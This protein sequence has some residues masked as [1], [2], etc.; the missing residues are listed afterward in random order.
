MMHFTTNFAFSNQFC[1]QPADVCATLR[2]KVSTSR[3]RSQYRQLWFYS[4]RIACQE[5]MCKFWTRTWLQLLDEGIRPLWDIK[6]HQSW[7]GRIQRQFTRPVSSDY[8]GPRRVR[9]KLDGPKERKWTVLKVDCRAK[10][11]GL[12][13]K[14]TVPDDS[15]RSFEP[16]LILFDFQTV[17][18]RGPSTWSHLGY[19]VRYMTVHFNPNKPSILTQDRPIL[20]LT[21][22]WKIR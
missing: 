5:H 10:V 14:W 3:F 6:Y 22:I 17:Y 18:N 11:D 13:P 19:P 21:R 2:E 8:L 9:S 20:E 15:G 16:T 12:K 4:E 7:N 1:V